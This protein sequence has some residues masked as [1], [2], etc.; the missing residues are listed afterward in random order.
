MLRTARTVLS[1]AAA[2]TMLGLVA[3]TGGGAQPTDQTVTVMYEHSDGF[4]ALDDL[5]QKIKPEFETAHQGVTVD[6]RPVEASDDDYTAQLQLA[7]RSAKTAPD[8]F[9][10]DSDR[11]RAEAGDGSLL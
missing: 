6:L 2:T 7:Q 1:A 8:V 3:C 10:E 9:Y 4:A 11:M 5:F